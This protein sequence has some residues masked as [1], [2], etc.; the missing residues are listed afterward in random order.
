MHAGLLRSIVFGA[1]ESKND[2]FAMD[3]VPFRVIVTDT[4]GVS[5]VLSFKNLSSAPK[6]I[7]CEDRMFAARDPAV[8]WA[9]ETGIS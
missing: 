5:A 9:G 2:G 4:R 8:G 3:I 7:A 1:S 6:V